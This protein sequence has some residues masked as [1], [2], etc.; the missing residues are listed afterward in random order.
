[1]LNSYTPIAVFP[2][3]NVTTFAMGLFH[4]CAVVQGTGQVV[5]VGKMIAGN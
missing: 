3:L 1:M 5:C 2:A 4:V